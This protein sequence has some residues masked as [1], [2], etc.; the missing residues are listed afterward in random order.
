MKLRG[1]V[2]LIKPFS[3]S[4][5][6]LYYA[7]TALMGSVLAS[8]GIRVA[9]TLKAVF[10]TLLAAFAIYAL[11]DV[12][13]VEVDRINAPERP[14]PSGRVSVAEAKAL[15]IVL[16][17]FALALALTGN[18][19]TF[20]FTLL[21]SALGI[22]YSL[23]PLRL[24]D[25]WF[26]GVCWGLGIAAT[27]LCGASPYTITMPVITASAML[28]ILTA[29]CGLIKDLKDLEGDRAKGI[30]TIPILIGEEKAAKLMTATF[31]AIIPLLPAYG[32]IFY[33]FNAFYTALTTLATA[34]FAYS[35]FMLKKSRSRSLYNK[36][37]K[38]QAISGFLLNIAFL[39]L[40]I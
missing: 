19:L 1:Y 26:A 27:V 36:A 37:Y 18:M 14:L 34:I 2:E 33:G 3:R 9:E 8:H 5:S 10:S 17:T 32:I 35:I 4:K 6:T 24:K 28:A 40:G 20:A 21:F 15:V 25:G 12:C 38:M 16:F 30:H 22:A 13:D 31:A 11:N 39:L 29:G 7:L 23:P